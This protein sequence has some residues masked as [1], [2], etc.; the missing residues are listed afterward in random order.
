MNSDGFGD[1][2]SLGSIWLQQRGLGTNLADGGFGQFEWA[3]IMAILFQG[4]GVSEKAL[5][6]KRYD[7][8]QLFKATLQYL[9]TTDFL[10]NPVVF[11][12]DESVSSDQNHPMFFDGKRGLNV[13]FKM[14]KWSYHMVNFELENMYPIITDDPPVAARGEHNPTEFK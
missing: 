1:A 6:S 8:Y 4:S 3:C 5:L 14:T 9:A 13:L 11:S 2:C 7:S 12:C 10:T